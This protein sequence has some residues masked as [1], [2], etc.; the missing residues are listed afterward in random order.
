MINFEKIKFRGKIINLFISNVLIFVFLFD[1]FTQ[2]EILKDNFFYSGKAIFSDLL[3]IIPNLEEFSNW[4][5]FDTY[6]KSSTEPF[7]RTMNYPLVWVYI[8]DFFS[9]FGNPAIIFG[10]IELFLYVLLANLILF[11]ANKNF[12]L[13]FFLL[14]SPPILLML[15]RGNID[16]FIFFILLSSILTKNYLSGI[17]LG[18]AI[19]LKYY[20]ILIL[21]FYFFFE[22]IN[23]KFLLGFIITIPMIVWTFLQLKMMLATTPVSFSTSFG[24]YS[25]ALFLIKV[26]NELFF[27]EIDKKYI[28]FFYLFSIFLFFTTSLIFNYFLKKDL[29]KILEILKLNKKELKLFILFSTLTILV[30][31][32]FS[33]FA[34]RIIFLMPPALIYLNNLDK[35]NKCFNFKKKSIYLLLAI[36]PF[37]FPWIIST[38]RE[39]LILL[40]YYSWAFYSFVVFI[41]IIFYFLIL[42]NFYLKKIRSVKINL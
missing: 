8:F 20:P 10:I 18:L 30:F 13:Y 21:P 15:E 31:F 3:V 34:Y 41:S 40:N 6:K 23:R 24:I 14:F 39:D 5:L 4:N 11:Q 35:I 26:I 22:K 2:G 1:I 29:V 12:Y 36:A 33:N 19:S 28:Y 32:V 7:T 42:Y 37:F 16:C 38:T 9:N 17:L 25:F 27:L